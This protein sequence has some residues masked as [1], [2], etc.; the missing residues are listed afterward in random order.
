[1]AVRWP[2]ALQQAPGVH[3]VTALCGVA[4]P[5]GW[6]EAAYDAQYAGVCAV[7]TACVKR[8]LCLQ[9][10]VVRSAVRCASGKL[11]PQALTRL[12]AALPHSI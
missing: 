2:N 5:G 9:H 1:M 8:L 6:H 4:G 10:F 7:W 3:M 11:V 12:V